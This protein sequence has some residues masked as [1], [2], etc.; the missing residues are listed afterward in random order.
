MPDLGRRGNVMGPQPIGKIVEPP[1]QM[2]AAAEELIEAL[3]AGKRNIVE[4]MTDAQ[5]LAE[6]GQIVAATAPGAYESF[7]FIGRARVA[8]HYFLKV[9]L[10]GRSASPKTL[11]FR[12]G[13]QDGRW[14][15][16]EASDL[17]GRRSAWTR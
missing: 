13:E 3:I 14:T 2:L 7:E 6:V 16:R 11:Q 10:S 8:K 5:A 4:A 17:S 12:L 15:V 9:R 1:A